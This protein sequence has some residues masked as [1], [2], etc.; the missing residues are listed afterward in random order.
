MGTI[1]NIVLF[2]FILGILVLIHE[3][4]HFLTAKKSGVHIYEFSIGMGPLVKT[5]KGKDGINYSIRALPIGGYVQM[6]GEIYEDDDT[7][8]IPK[9][10]FMCNR[11][12][13]Q[14]LIVLCAGVF[15]NFLLAIFLLF[16]IAIFNGAP[17]LKPII[18]GVVENGAAAN[19]GMREGDLIKEV[20]HSKTK[21][22]DKAQILLIIKDK[23]NTYDIL[24]EHKDGEEELLHISP[25]VEKVNGEEVKT[26]GIYVENSREKGFIPSVKYAFG[27]LFATME[28]MWI[29]LANLFTGKISINSLS[30]PIGIYTVVGESRKAG[31]ENVVYLVAYLSINLG[32]MN[33]LPIPAL[34]GGHVLFLLIELITRKKVNQKVESIATTI[35]LSLLM[36]LMLY[37]TIHDVIK[38]F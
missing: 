1:I 30:G 10:K 6:A 36:L 2:L 31:L 12:W 24:V 14:R 20:N 8:K 23:D 25:K 27:K 19:A 16:L 34:D 15:N 18:S 38:L 29:T 11:P 33:I 22:W 13:Y 4:G 37:I 7:D 26:F 5:I 3:L 32:V 17:N 21:T 35:F 28:Q 9:E